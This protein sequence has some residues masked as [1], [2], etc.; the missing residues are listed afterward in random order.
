MSSGVSRSMVSF[1]PPIH[2]LAPGSVT[3]WDSVT[4]SSH[5]IPMTGSS[6]LPI[7]GGQRVVEA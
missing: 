1:D 5:Y 6:W 3:W 2:A 4:S 7:V